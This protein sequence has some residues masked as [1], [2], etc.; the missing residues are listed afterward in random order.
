MKFN[1]SFSAVEDDVQIDPKDMH[2]YK[3]LVNSM[4]HDFRNRILKLLDEYVEMTVTELYVKLRCEQSV[5]SQHLAILRKANLVNTYRDGKF[6][7]YKLYIKGK[8][9]L[10]RLC[11]SVSK[12]RDEQKAIQGAFDVFRALSN[13]TRI[14]ILDFIDRRSITT[15]NPIYNSLKIEQSICS[16]N[17]KVLRDAGILQQIRK[18]KFVEYFIDY[19][20]LKLIK[21]SIERYEGTIVKV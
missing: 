4:N 8:K 10:L 14:R 17:L 7:H 3:H 11:R 19:E 6:I 9:G 1:Y 15:V 13:D 21:Q 2:Y 5:A 16:Q 12:S 18:G 20:Y